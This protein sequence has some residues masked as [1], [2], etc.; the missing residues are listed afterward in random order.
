MVLLNRLG[1]RP[2]GDEPH[3]VAR[4]LPVAG[5]VGFA[6]D[7]IEGNDARV[8]ELPGDAG[9]LQ[10]AGSQ[11]RVTDAVGPQL[12]EHHVAAEEAS[13]ASQTCPSP[14]VR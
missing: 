14:P 3:R 6:E 4:V 5:F 11:P 8:F 1:E 12:L 13:R 7:V 2:A 10:E 9:L